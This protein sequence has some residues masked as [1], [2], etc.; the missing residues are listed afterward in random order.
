MKIGVT[1]RIVQADGYIEPRDALAQDWG[2]FLAAAL[3]NAGWMPLPNLGADDIVPYCERWGIDRL[4]L[5]GGD[6]L[7]AAA[8]RD[9]TERG[10]LDW[11]EAGEIP[12]L[13]I[14]RGMQ[15]L[16][17]RAGT[18]LHEIDGHVAMRHPLQGE[19][20]DVVNSFHRLG[21]E[22]CPAG[23]GVT[24]RTDDGSIE[25]I[26][27]SRLPWAGWMWHPEREASPSPIDIHAIE[28]LFR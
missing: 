5:S 25:A 7:G 19:R 28:S 14:C 10:L 4:I 15:L 1:M 21:L 26:Y 17:D 27:H 2:R 8:L 12:V 3:P 13:G 20:S 9:A 24:A 23:Y 22:A 18:S 11:A 6:D 16:A